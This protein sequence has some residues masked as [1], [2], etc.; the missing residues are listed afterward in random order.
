L[1]KIRQQFVEEFFLKSVAY[2][3]Y[4]YMFKN[5]DVVV[6][7]ILSILDKATADK[8]YSDEFLGLDTASKLYYWFAAYEGKKGSYMYNF[9]Q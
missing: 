6:N 3:A 7:V 9:I 1:T 4:N 5:K 8:I 2:Q